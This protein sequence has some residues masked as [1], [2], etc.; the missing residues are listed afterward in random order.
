MCRKS[1]EKCY[2]YIKLNSTIAL[3]TMKVFLDWSAS[4][5][6]FK[7]KFHYKRFIFNN[8]CPSYL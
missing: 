3:K 4:V 6:E 5:K 8:S 1:A 7:V 2:V